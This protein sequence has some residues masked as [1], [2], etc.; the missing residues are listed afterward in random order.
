VF[1]L[2]LCQSSNGGQI[3][4][5]FQWCVAVKNITYVQQSIRTT[6]TDFGLE[7]IVTSLVHT[8]N[9]TSAE[10]CRQ[11]IQTML[12]NGISEVSRKIREMLEQAAEKV[13][14]INEQSFLTL[15]HTI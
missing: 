1:P 13:S 2:K 12:D 3:F 9:Y 8:G 11:T 5:I 10:I 15:C 14:A 7:A 6:V 4:N